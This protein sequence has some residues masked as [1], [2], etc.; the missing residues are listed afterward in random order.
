MYFSMTARKNV[1]D[2]RTS[3]E[4]KITDYELPY[5]ETRAS[6]VNANGVIEKLD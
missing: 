1:Y 2:V 5:K 3:E 4:M 6:N